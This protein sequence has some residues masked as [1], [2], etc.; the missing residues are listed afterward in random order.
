M[1]LVRTTVRSRL[2]VK[3]SPEKTN[4][5]PCKKI[6]L[7]KQTSISPCKKYFCKNKLVLAL[8]KNSPAK[9]ID[10]LYMINYGE[11]GEETMF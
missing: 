1:S 9:Q 6:V 2:L 10:D 3:I 5:S 8:A 4:I 7:Q 11:K